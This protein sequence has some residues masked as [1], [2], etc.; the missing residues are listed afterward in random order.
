MNTYIYYWTLLLRGQSA[1]GLWLH[2]ADTA[3]YTSCIPNLH[4]KKLVLY[5]PNQNTLSD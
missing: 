3:D 1:G 2:L 5:E 4:R